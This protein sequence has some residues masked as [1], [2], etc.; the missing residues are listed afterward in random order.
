MLIR[1][2]IVGGVCAADWYWNGCVNQ[3]VRCKL[4]DIML[5][6]WY[7][8]ILAGVCAAD[9]YWNGCVNQMI[10]YFLNWLIRWYYAIVAG[11]C[12]VVPYFTD[13]HFRQ[14]PESIIAKR[15]EPAL[16]NC[17]AIQGQTTPRIQWMKDGE[18]L[19]DS[20]RRCF[21]VTLCVCVCVYMRTS[22]W[23]ILLLLYAFMYTTLLVL[24]LQYGVSC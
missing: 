8:A 6:G 24:L 5:I 15:G 17:S 20:H 10:L 18:Y 12:G 16:L 21:S 13:F 7:Y 3:M 23:C 19:Q 9:W 14:E 4:D 22:L 11:V 1:Y 2:A